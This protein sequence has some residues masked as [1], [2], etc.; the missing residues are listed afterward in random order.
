M[1]SCIGC[2]AYVGEIDAMRWATGIYLL[3]PQKAGRNLIMRV[4]SLWLMGTG[5][6]QEWIEHVCV[7]EG[8]VERGC[9][10]VSTCL[11]VSLWRSPMLMLVNVFIYLHVHTYDTCGGLPFLLTPPINVMHINTTKWEKGNFNTR[12]SIYE[13]IQ[14]TW[15]SVEKLKM[16]HVCSGKDRLLSFTTG[17]YFVPRVLTRG[18]WE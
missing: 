18:T 12:R 3:L 11:C 13:K 14:L 6:I 8:G 5:S 2:Q 10:S 16:F 4:M 7:W 15:H 17:I 9:C 1:T